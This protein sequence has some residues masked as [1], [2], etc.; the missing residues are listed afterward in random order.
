MTDINLQPLFQFPETVDTLISYLEATRKALRTGQVEPIRHFLEVR[1][2]GKKDREYL[3]AVMTKWITLL[4]MGQGE[5]V[6]GKQELMGRM[7]IGFV[8]SRL[9]D[10]VVLQRV[11][12]PK[13]AFTD[14]SRT[15][16]KTVPVSS[17]IRA[18]KRNVKL[19]LESFTIPSSKVKEFGLTF[20]MARILLRA[21]LE[22][23]AVSDDGLASMPTGFATTNAD[24]VREEVTYFELIEAIDQG[25]SE[26]EAI[27][28]EGVYIRLSVSTE[29]IFIPSLMGLLMKRIPHIIEMLEKL[30]YADK[31]P[32][33]LKALK[34]VQEVVEVIQ[35]DK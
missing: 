8:Q 17:Q 29:S 10:K 18:E 13:K 16:L 21:G 14:K 12:E 1:L 34:A 30:K 32:R 35:S 3:L 6:Q 2:Q 5:T 7:P 23:L 33:L 11:I 28:D 27:E 22:E 25:M 26:P 20:G 15:P 4:R 19:A 24:G 9:R 31:Y